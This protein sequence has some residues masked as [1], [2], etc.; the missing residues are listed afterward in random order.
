VSDIIGF[1]DNIRDLSNEN[2]FQFEFVCERCGNGY[3]SPFAN[4]A[5]EKGRGLL[6]GAGSLFGGKLAELSYATQQLAYDRGTNSKA[7]DKAMTSA[8]DSVKDQF[9][10]CRG[11]GN[12]VCVPVC[13]NHEIGQ[14]LVCSPSIAEEISRAQAQ[15]Q[16]EQVQQKVRETDW[17]QNL[18]LTTRAKLTCPSCGEKVDGGKFCQSCGAKL[19]KT[20]FCSE[21]GTEMAEGA[22]FCPECGH[23]SG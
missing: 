21:C 7:K 9:K 18:D 23:R 4:N 17:T 19:A 11:C 8:V 16:I 14:C 3:R 6:R 2:G 5:M 13:W 22:K 10:Q 15:A 1:T 12:W 20:S